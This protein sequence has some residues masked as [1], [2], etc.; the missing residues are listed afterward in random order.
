[1]LSRAFSLQVS[2]SSSFS[3]HRSPVSKFCPVSPYPAVSF[4]L[5][6]DIGMRF[7]TLFVALLSLPLRSSSLFL[8]SNASPLARV[9]LYILLYVL[10]ASVCDLAPLSVPFIPPLSSVYVSKRT[11]SFS[12]FPM[13]FWMQRRGNGSTTPLSLRIGTYIGTYMRPSAP[14]VETW[15]ILIDRR[16]T[17]YDEYSGRHYDYLIPL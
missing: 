14:T 2:L 9:F 16:R 1:M 3:L 12:P 8:F 13:Y 6:A 15:K 4:C 11:G 7:S 5:V 17:S 10:S